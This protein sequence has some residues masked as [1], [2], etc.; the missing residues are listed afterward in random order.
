MDKVEAKNVR[1]KLL[2]SKPE[3]FTALLE[4]ISFNID[5]LGFDSLYDFVHS[6]VGRGGLGLNDSRLNALL[7]FNPSYEHKAVELAKKLNLAERAKENATVGAENSKNLRKLGGGSTE[8]RIGKLKRDFPEV[9]EQLC[10]G[11]FKN[12]REAERAA[13]V[14]PPKK[15]LKRFSIDLDDLVGSKKRVNELINK[16]ITQNDASFG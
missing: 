3:Q 8:Y 9:A 6:D 4:S 5:V 2:N 10:N 12:V 15:R 11:E 14:Q 7:Y 13:G 16:L 1:D